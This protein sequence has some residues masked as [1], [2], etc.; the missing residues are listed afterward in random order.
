MTSLPQFGGSEVLQ[1]LEGHNLLNP[2]VTTAEHLAVSVP[3]G[4]N[5]HLARLKALATILHLQ[6]TLPQHKRLGR[7]L[8]TSFQNINLV[9]DGG[10]SS[11]PQSTHTTVASC[12]K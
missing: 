10:F 5:T 7:G 6:Q 9:S 12:Y 2:L 3:V 8:K 1:V 11:T 4:V